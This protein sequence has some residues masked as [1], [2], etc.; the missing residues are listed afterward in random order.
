MSDQITNKIVSMLDQIQAGVTNVAPQAIDLMLKVVS[1]KGIIHIAT[2]IFFLCIAIFCAVIVYKIILG[3]KEY[4]KQRKEIENKIQLGLLSY[5]DRKFEQ[6]ISHSMAIFGIC[7]VVSFFISAVFLLNLWNYI[8]I[9]N[10]KLYLANEVIEKVINK[11][12]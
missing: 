11:G 10:P 1:V 9:F 12:K 4:E 5:E 3:Y 7:G 8:A 6:D 2:G